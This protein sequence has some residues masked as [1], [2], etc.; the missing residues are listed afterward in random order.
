MCCVYWGAVWAHILPHLHGIDFV[1][2]RHH[3]LV[4]LGL[5]ALG[6]RAGDTGGREMP[7]VRQRSAEDKHE[8]MAATDEVE[9]G[10][11]ALI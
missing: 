6:T 8:Q 10:G 1:W 5:V 9:R 11:R 7:H 3:S 2:L 4:S